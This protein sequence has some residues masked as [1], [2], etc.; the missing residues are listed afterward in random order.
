MRSHPPTFTPIAFLLLLMLGANQTKIAVAS[1]SLSIVKINHPVSFAENLI[2]LGKEIAATGDV[3]IALQM[4]DR[5]V[6]MAETIE[7]KSSKINALSDIAIK[8]AEVGQTEKAK[9][10]FD[11]AV[12]LTKQRDENFTLYQQEPALRDV[13][14]KVAQ[15]GLIEKALQLTKTI[16]SNYRQAEALNAIAPILAEKGQ[17]EPAKKILSEALQKARGIT[18]DYV[19]ESNGSCGNDKFDILAKI[20]GNLSLLSQFKQALQVA[21]SVTGC[22]SASGESTEDYQTM[23]YLG[24]LAHLANAEQVKQTWTSAQTMKNDIEKAEVWSAI[25]VKL[26]AMNETNLALSVAAKISQQ[27]P[28][29]TKIDSG[30][31]MREFGVKE[32][33]LGDIAIKLAELG[34]FDAAKQV[35]QMIRE[36]TPQESAANQEFNSTDRPSIKSLIWVEI[37]HQLAKA[38][39]VDMALQIAKSIQDREGKAL[40]IIAIAQQ[41]QQ[42]G[43]PSPADKFFSQNLQLPPIPQGNNFSGNQSIIRIV[44]ALTKAGYIERGL[45]I[46]NAIND[47][48]SKEEA[49]ADIASQ[50]T[51]IGQ[52]DR[53]LQ[54]ANTLTFPGFKERAFSKIA[55]K[56]VELGQ[57]EPALQAAKNLSDNTKD[58]ILAKIADAFAKLGK[59]EEALQVSQTI[60]SQEI[61]A[62]AIA[63]IAAR[64]I[65]IKG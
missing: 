18:G 60:A 15:A 17:L 61:K 64:L 35:A 11:R 22:S 42:T 23:A 37:A 57:L 3:D 32:K 46:A 28:S 51:E 41:L 25:A 14:I 59:T 27:I 4:F 58:E 12:Q 31:A 1:P 10:L 30:S 40:A 26:A 54:I 63:N 9:Q 19:Y 21:Q 6:Q 55:S 62:S 44:S 7:D 8:L 53:A 48:S 52:V 29:I 2:T 38:K 39:Q 13:A 16:S 65:Q 43:Y 50:L 36:L 49:L 34:Q 5:A 47:S 56:Y 45:Q 20:A 33:A 24:I